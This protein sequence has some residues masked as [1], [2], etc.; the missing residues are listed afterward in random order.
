MTTDQEFPAGS[1]H[2]VVRPGCALWAFD[3][4]RSGFTRIPLDVGDVIESL[5]HTPGWGADPGYGIHFKSRF[6]HAS[7]RPSTGGVFAFR[8]A[9]GCLERTDDN[10]PV[11]ITGGQPQ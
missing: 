2:V 6:P 11:S 5:G 9:A 4:A 1:R 7:F 10:T 3:P 8:P